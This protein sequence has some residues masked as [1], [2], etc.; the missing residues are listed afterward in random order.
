MMMFGG[1]V[2]LVDSF[3]LC[4]AEKKLVEAPFTVPT[5]NDISLNY[6]SLPINFE[7]ITP[8]MFPFHKFMIGGFM[9]WIFPLVLYKTPARKH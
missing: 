5:T 7:D 2:F 8:H 6:H 4:F 3:W 1:Y 9:S